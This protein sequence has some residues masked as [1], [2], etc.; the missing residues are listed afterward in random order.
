VLDDGH[1]V[2]VDSTMPGPEIHA[3]S[4]A[5]ALAGFPLR[6]VSARTA[7]RETLG[8]GLLLALALIV[9]ALAGRAVRIARGG[10]G[11]LLDAPGLVAVA[12]LGALAAGTWLLVAQLEFN[13]GTVV[14]LLPVL[15]ALAGSTAAALTASVVVSRRTR[16]DVRAR[17]ADREE[18]IVTRVM[19]STER[20]RAVTASDIIAG[21]VIDRPIAGGGM[22]E[23]YSAVQSR[24]GRRV[25]L[26]L[27]RSEH[28]RDRAYRRRFVDEAHRASGFSHPNVITVIDVGD[29]DGVLFIA[30]QL[31]VGSNLSESLS[32]VGFLDAA[33]AVRLV[34]RIACA[35]DAAHAEGIFHRDVKPANILIPDRSPEHPLLTDFGVARTAAE[36]GRPAGV[37][38]TLAYLAPER[39]DGRE[40]GRAA[41]VY[42]LAAVLF[43]CLTGEVPFP[44]D[45]R[46]EIAEAHRSAARPAVSRIRP[47]LGTRIDAVVATGLAIDPH[48]RYRTATAF[49]HAAAEALGAEVTDDERD[50]GQPRAERRRATEQP[51]AGDDV[52][53]TE[54]G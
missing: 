25:A 50:A 2:P 21:Y 30:M 48:A 12:A 41:D 45:T 46:R 39:L 28:A 54:L 37:E 49:T 53:P 22:G 42:A 52:E 31:V 10:G 8:A 20:S 43:E 6:A 13:A 5:T 19:A 1:R 14:E 44:R 9:V 18:G 40:S 23:V 47:E 32:N 27:I 35:L 3:A 36:S 11:V 51:T 4:I 29:D 33:Y 34:H 17:F 26:K 24:L 16:R 38:G 15:A 7:Q